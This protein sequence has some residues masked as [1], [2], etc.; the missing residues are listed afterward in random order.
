MD[1]T[2]LY[3][4]LIADKK[5]RNENKGNSYIAHYANIVSFGSQEKSV[6]DDIQKQIDDYYNID[7]PNSN[8][9]ATKQVTDTEV[10]AYLAELK[11][12]YKKEKIDILVT[13]S[14]NSIFEAIIKPFGLAKILFQDRNG[15]DVTTPHNL[16]EGVFVN[17]KSKEK[18]EQLSQ[19]PY[20][21]KEYEQGF[22]EQRK[23][24]F[25]K[26]EPIIDYLTGKTLPKDGQSHLDH[27]VPLK[28]IHD[29]IVQRY[30]IDKIELVKLVNN[31]TNLKFTHSSINQSKGDKSM[32]KFLSHS[33]EGKNNVER[34]E[35]D[36]KKAL[37]ADKKARKQFSNEVNKK[38]TKHVLIG[39]SGASVKMGFQ[40]A[41]GL[42]LYEFS[43]SVFDE[44]AS[45]INN[46]FYTEGNEGQFFNELRIRFARVVDNIVS[47][48]QNIVSNF[49]D[50]FLSGFLS[51]IAT[52]IIN[53]FITTGKN[54][55]KLI[56]EGLLSL[57][58]AFKMILFPPDN[59]S[60]SEAAHEASKIIVS[61]LALVGGIILEESISKVL[62]P[63]LGLGSIIASIIAGIVTGLSMCLLTYLIDKA[64]FF[65]VEA[66]KEQAYIEK[67]LD[68]SIQTSI[69]N[70]N[71]IHKQIED[72]SDVFA[73]VKLL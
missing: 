4:K 6:L 11:E 59:V 60:L 43:K 53:M 62:P 32:P 51:S 30:Y 37:A 22:S 52:S 71:T 8:D 33:K 36:E 38:I 12:A 70:I 69:D 42:V 28:E 41:I 44:V 34:F 17:D 9:F 15:G 47:K 49:A 16:K 40:Q 35:I 24:E 31:N 2:K 45:M 10:K 61:S 21:R 57:L 64:D 14:K 63:L 67:H 55:V 56:R 3:K 66:K 46:G 58:K 27:I 13:E 18:Y 73:D 5:Q 50:G 26:N 65:G 72:C 25:Q 29:N 39:A 20:N 19:E 1:K 54:I 23:K 68:N 7:L 48:W